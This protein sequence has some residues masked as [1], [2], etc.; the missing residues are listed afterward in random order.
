MENSLR[1]C[2]V[3]LGCFGLAGLTQPL[4]AVPIGHSQELP[5]LLVDS[6]A[7]AVLKASSL[8]AIFLPLFSSFLT[9]LQLHSSFIPIPRALCLP[10]TR[11]NT[12]LT[13]FFEARRA[14]CSDYLATESLSVLL[15][16][17]R[18]FAP[19]RP[20]PFSPPPSRPFD[21]DSQS[22]QTSQI[23]LAPPAE[24]A[25]PSTPARRPTLSPS[26][27]LRP[28]TSQDKATLYSPPP[29]SSS[30]MTPPPSTQIPGAPLRRSR[31]RSRSSHRSFL[32]SPPDTIDKSLCAAYG[33]SENLPSVQDIETADEAQLRTIAKELLSVAQESRMSA[34]H[35]KLQNSLQTLASSEAVKRAEVE[36]QLA[37]RE[38]EI[39]QSSE[40]RDRHSTPASKTSALN[41]QL[42]TALR[43]N[44][45]LERVN[46][47]L[48]T[49]LRRA[50]RLI[51][52]EKEKFEL[53]EEENGLLKKRI[54]DNREHFSRM[55]DQGSL[56]S[57]PRAEFQAPQRKPISTYPENTESHLSRGG[58]HDAFA[59]LL[60]ADQVL[61][62]ESASV[63]T[64]PDRNQ[65][66]HSGHV[67]GAHSMS[68]LP[69][70]PSR[71]RAFYEAQYMTPGSK[72]FD[73][74]V[75]ISDIVSHER[76]AERD[77]H[78]RDSTISASD[79]E[80]AVI[81]ED[82]PP[83]QASSMATNM[84]RRYPGDHSARAPA[85]VG[86]SNNLLQT[87]LFGRVQKA[88]VERPS[89]SKRK[90]DFEEDKS[91]TAKKTKAPA[92]VGLGIGPWG[93]SRA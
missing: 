16:W 32:A 47:T 55:I 13:R 75:K 23:S 4:P 9:P 24:I 51:Q 63:A 17:T 50:K 71:S 73:G 77:G 92:N 61:N 57:S 86:R 66:R 85:N 87:K 14:A 48:E 53:L 60:A 41:D 83:S 8:R 12:E 90:A 62:G 81:D 25:V 91:V 39:L 78:D 76:Q 52:E 44:Q 22:S 34:L 43:R 64:T 26:P 82:V 29:I 38:V 67:R 74:R 93:T 19:V 45:D 6:A 58:S 7:R 88:G 54:R 49:R 31:S 33:A 70:T 40:Y 56:S 3:Q 15:R 30:D 89:P 27:D 11:L 69:A 59:A 18:E 36:Q 10:L 1:R 46:A 21:M 80:E 79:A 2:P 65:R 37:R 84:L 20:L 68:S 5:S 35:F 28:M 72:Q 42:Q